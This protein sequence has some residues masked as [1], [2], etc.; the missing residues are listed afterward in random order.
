MDY[1]NIWFSEIIIFFSFSFS[2]LSWEYLAVSGF[3]L[4][5][6]S[7]EVEAREE[8]ME[9]TSKKIKNLLFNDA[10]VNLSFSLRC[11]YIQIMVELGLSLNVL[12]F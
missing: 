10:A 8:E 5:S 1:K 7:L 3:P 6:S 2:F 4:D 9:T 11:I 12:S